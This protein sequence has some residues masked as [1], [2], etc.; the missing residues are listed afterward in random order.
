MSFSDLFQTIKKDWEDHQGN[1]VITRASKRVL[2]FIKENNVVMVTGN[3]GVGKTATMQHVALEM[4]EI[5]YDVIPVDDP[6]FII[7]Y[8]SPSKRVLFVFD[9]CCGISTLSIIRLQQWRDCIAKIKIILKK[10]KSKTKILLGS[11]L[12]IT[13]DARL[14]ELS[15]LHSCVCDLNANDLRLIPIEKYQYFIL[16]QMSDKFHM[17]HF[18]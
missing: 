9:D 16:E 15:I 5:G 12:Q 13:K 3:I 18:R 8:H 1:F 2:K 4:K 6:N 10:G 14:K 7:R 17:I 11:R